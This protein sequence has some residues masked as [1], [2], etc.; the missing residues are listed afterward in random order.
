MNKCRIFC[1]LDDVLWDL[2]PHWIEYNNQLHELYRDNYDLLSTNY[3]IYDT[4]EFQDKFSSQYTKD[5][6]FRILDSS[7]FWEGIKTT[8]NR[9]ATL[10]ELNNNSDIELYI[11]TSTD[12]RHSS[13]IARFTKLFPFINDNQII[14]CHDKWLLDGDIWID[15]KPETLE[16]CSQKGKVIKVSKP[17]NETAYSDLYINDFA[18]LHMNEYFYDMIAYIIKEKDYNEKR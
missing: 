6:F 8:S 2:L 15:D 7:I 4:W 12:W 14:L 17:Y 18:E 13:K 16:K 9:I 5:N 10:K 3:F 1:D 11:V